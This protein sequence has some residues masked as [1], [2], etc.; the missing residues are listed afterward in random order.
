MTRSPPPRPLRLA[1]QVVEVELVP[2]PVI[3][4]VGSP[5]FLKW[6]LAASAETEI[7]N[8]AARQTNKAKSILESRVFKVESFLGK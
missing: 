6:G 2:A 3:V 1:V 4:Q 5:P 7:A 8:A